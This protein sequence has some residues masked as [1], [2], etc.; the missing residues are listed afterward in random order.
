MTEPCKM[1]YGH[2]SYAFID[3]L[4]GLRV[5]FVVHCDSVNVKEA[6]PRPHH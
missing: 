2:T 1:Q 4:Q 6:Y 5:M 3:V